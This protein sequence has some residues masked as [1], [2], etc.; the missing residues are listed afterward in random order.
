MDTMKLT[1]KR[2]E[3]FWSKVDKSGECWLWTGYVMKSGYGQYSPFKALSQYV[4]RAAY[5]LVNGSIPEGLMVDHVC[6][7]RHCVRPLHLR[8]ATNG[9]NQQNRKGPAATGTSGHRGVTLHA[10]GK[11][12]AQVQHNGKGFYLGLFNDPEEAAR[13]AAAKRAELFTHA[14]D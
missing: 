12:Q 11:W 8:L 9:Q 14:R 1:A 3:A 13:V 2:L 7:V 5:L 4:H 10:C 6:H